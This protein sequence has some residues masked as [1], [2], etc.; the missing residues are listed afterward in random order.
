MAKEEAALAARRAQAAGEV[1]PSGAVAQVGPLIRAMRPRQWTKNGIVF[2]AFVFSVGQQYHLSDGEPWTRWGVVVAQH[3]W[4]A[5]PMA[6]AAVSVETGFPLALFSR[7]ARWVLVPAGLMFLVGIRALMG[8]TFEQFMLC[9]IFWVPWDRVWTAIRIRLPEPA[10]R[11]R[12]AAEGES[13]PVA[14]AWT[15]RG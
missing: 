15:E 6:T 9:D 7:R 14:T 12:G 4:M 3:R 10:A 2:L 5:R 11:M 13:S 8:P 1:R